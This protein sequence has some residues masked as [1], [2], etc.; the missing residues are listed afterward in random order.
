MA[1][2][3]NAK[4][5]ATPAS[6]QK[7]NELKFGFAALSPDGRFVAAAQANSGAWVWSVASGRTMVQASLDPYSMAFSPDGR[8]IAFGAYQKVVLWDVESDRVLR[9][10]TGMHDTVDI[11]EFSPDG[12][13]LGTASGEV[14]RIWDTHSGRLLHVIRHHGYLTSISFSS[15]GKLMVS[16]GADQRVRI[17]SVS[18][19]STIRTLRGHSGTV[20]DAIFA[21]QGATVAS[22][23]RQDGT[24]RIWNARSGRCLQTLRPGSA[25]VESVAF[26][27]DG[28][29]LV[30]GLSTSG[31]DTA[32]AT[33]WSVA[34]G[35]LIGTLRIPRSAATERNLSTASFSPDGTHVL[36]VTDDAARI[37]QST[38]G[39]LLHALHSPEYDSISDAAFSRDGRTV[40]TVT[41]FGSVQLWD[42]TTGRTARILHRSTD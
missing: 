4:L 9:T 12:R 34:S 39:R 35:G 42:A 20:N 36:T 17:S 29:S 23:G 11:V 22:G 27:A 10:L 16:A 40:V 13:R 8:Q 5:G 26:S 3:A 37:W 21:P 1:L 24:V 6:S 14:A 25:G 41:L 18:S 31:A 7:A 32:V 15:D 28:R 33:I 19:G 2:T 38:G 30:T